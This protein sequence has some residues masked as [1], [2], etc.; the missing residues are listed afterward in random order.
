MLIIN[1]KMGFMNFRSYSKINARRLLFKITW[2]FVLH[3][4]QDLLMLCGP[5]SVSRHRLG[6]I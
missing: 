1:N 3:P 6:V 2:I 5:I 4:P